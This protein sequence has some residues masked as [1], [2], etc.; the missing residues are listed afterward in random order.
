M[1]EEFTLD[2]SRPTTEFEAYLNLEANERIIFSGI[3]GS[4]KTYFLRRFFNNHEKYFTIFI[5]PTNYSIAQN[6][7]IFQLIKYDILYQ[8]IVKE[9]YL[10]KVEPSDLETIPF[11]KFTDTIRALEPFVKSIPKLGKYIT[12]AADSIFR[13]KELLDEK[14]KAI[15]TDEGKKIAHFINQFQNTEGSVY[16]NDIFSQLI[17]DLLSRVKG[18]KKSV[19]LVVDDLDRIDPEHMFRIMN[20]FAA[21]FK[22]DGIEEA[23]NKFGLNK[24]VLCCDIENIRAIFRSKY[25]IGVDF[26]GYIDKFFS[27]DIFHYNNKQTVVDSV[28]QLLISINIDVEKRSKNVWTS[29]ASN[30]LRFL[31]VLISSLILSDKLNLRTLKKV[32]CLEYNMPVY[33]IHFEGKRLMNWRIPIITIFDFLVFLFGNPESALVALKGMEFMSFHHENA[34]HPDYELSEDSYC[35]IFCE[36]IAVLKNRFNGLQPDH[37]FSCNDVTHSPLP[38]YLIQ[39]RSNHLNYSQDAFLLGR[40]GRLNG[41]YDLNIKSQLTLQLLQSKFI[42]AFQIYTKAKISTFQKR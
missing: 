6:A 18:D 20:V 31:I 15:E 1:M 42:E 21:H 19:V 8:I 12:A 16:E 17:F 23:D 39:S 7:D 2:I 10:E 4:G 28:A 35:D 34:T 29:H 41:T 38:Y 24:V 37:D 32:Y 36:I 9:T 5:D 11:L 14:K 3:F 26:N 13:L 25:G 27:R 30:Y 40:I 33:F 22:Q